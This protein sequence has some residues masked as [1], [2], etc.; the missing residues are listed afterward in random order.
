MMD[1]ERFNDELE[2]FLKGNPEHIVGYK[3]IDGEPMTDQVTTRAFMIWKM[4]RDGTPEWHKKIV[5]ERFDAFIS[6]AQ[7]NAGQ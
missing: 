5:L 7:R 6:H 2:E 4:D 3:L 1:Q